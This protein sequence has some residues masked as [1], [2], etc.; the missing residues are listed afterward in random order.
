MLP[1][2]ST[3]SIYGMRLRDQ[4]KGYLQ[5]THI[6][7]IVCECVCQTSC[8]E[9]SIILF[10]K[11]MCVVKKHAWLWPKRVHPSFYQSMY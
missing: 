6:F 9:E 8:Q 11:C 5:Y 3:V 10:K 1:H 7:A 2:L 4:P